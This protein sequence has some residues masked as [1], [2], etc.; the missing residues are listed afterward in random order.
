MSGRRKRAEKQDREFSL[1]G[2][3]W[4]SLANTDMVIRKA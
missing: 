4:N 2:R 1:M 3:D